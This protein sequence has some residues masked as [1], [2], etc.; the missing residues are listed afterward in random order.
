MRCRVGPGW[1]RGM[2]TTH[3]PAHFTAVDVN[4][5][6]FLIGFLDARY[7]L[8]GEL[9][10]KELIV[11]A[12]DLRPG[13]AVLDVGSGTGV[14][15]CRLADPVAPPDTTGS[16]VCLDLS[17]HMVTEARRPSTQAG[18]AAEFVER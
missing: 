4:N 3:D 6:D 11:D 5:A 2:N 15:T 13:L 14:D 12:L 7:D 16:A 17:A 1:G 9:R 8:P 10:V 18:A